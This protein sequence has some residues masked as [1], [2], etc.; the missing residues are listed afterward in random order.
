LVIRTLDSELD[1]DPQ[2]GKTLDPDRLRIKSV[3]IHTPE[4][5]S[6]FFLS[7][8]ESFGYF[9]I[10]CAEIKIFYLEIPGQKSNRSA[11]VEYRNVELMFYTRSV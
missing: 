5:I 6:T 9:Y 4:C 1:P 7:I 11:H 3:R 2:L 8:I 10:V